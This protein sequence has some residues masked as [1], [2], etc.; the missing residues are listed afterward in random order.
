MEPKIFKVLA[1]Y[2][3]STRLVRDTR[4]K[5]EEKL[6]FFLYMRSHNASYEDLQLTFGHSND[7]FQHHMKHFFNKAIPTLSSF[8]HASQ[9]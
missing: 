8:S 9:S 7:T 3:R 1:N 6:G 5:V 4:I 2:L